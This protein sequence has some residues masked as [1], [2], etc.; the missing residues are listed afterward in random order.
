[1][2]PVFQCRF[3][4][5]T[6]SKT[7]WNS[8]RC[9]GNMR[10]LGDHFLSATQR[11]SGTDAD[12]QPADADYPASESLLEPEDINAPHERPIPESTVQALATSALD[13]GPPADLSRT[14][15]RDLRTSYDWTSTM[16]MGNDAVS[17]MV[18]DEPQG[19]KP[20][21]EAVVW[22]QNMTSHNHPYP[23]QLWQYCPV[24]P[25]PTQ[26]SMLNDPA[27]FITKTI[28]V[29]GPNL[30]LPSPG[31]STSA[32]SPPTL[33]PTS[34][35]P[36][37]RARK[38]GR[39]RIYEDDRDDKK[40][41]NDKSVPRK[42][43]ARTTTPCSRTSNGQSGPKEDQHE[44]AQSRTRYRN[45]TAARR[46]RDK[47]RCLID[48]VEAEEHEASKLRRA[49]TEQASD[50]QGEVF[51]LK[52]KIFEHARCECPLIQAYLKGAAQGYGKYSRG[53]WG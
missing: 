32:A 8:F 40:N 22:D 20:D 46:Y 9:S 16:Q 48:K 24:S 36:P 12:M 53:C 42:K 50:L 30:W 4:D 3:T 18:G 51:A 26:A 31:T 27:P 38:R 34:P 33:T 15:D 21:L 7:D 37:K 1:M 19:I 39:P 17:G 29:P 41:D 43:P 47:L 6:C 49:L 44:R 2:F 5:I 13:H 25:D 14:L 35:T 52:N 11:D 45:R 28:P 23:T 10:Y